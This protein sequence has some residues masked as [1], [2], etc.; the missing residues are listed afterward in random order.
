M[1]PLEARG[2]LALVSLIRDREPDPDEWS[3]T[4]VKLT[5]LYDVLYI[6]G[7]GPHEIERRNQRQAQRRALGR[8]Q[9]DGFVT[10]LAL[11]WVNVD[12]EC[13]WRW[14]GGGRRRDPDE[15][16][17]REDTPRWK[18]I[19]VTDDGFRAADLVAAQGGAA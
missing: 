7:D 18:L 9:R 8:L 13:L 11:A 10:P 3:L 1:S 12:D 15:H 14:Q 19:G 17:Y 4:F 6:P 16:G 2:L 5:E